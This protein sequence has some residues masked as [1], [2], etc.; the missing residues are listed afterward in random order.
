MQHKC[1]LGT[2]RIKVF[3]SSSMAKGEPLEQRAALM[4]FFERMLP[5]YE[6]YFFETDASPQSAEKDYLS[7]LED[8]D[9]V[10]L[11]LQGSVRDGVKKEYDAARRKGKRILAFTCTG[12]RRNRA[13]TEFVC[14]VRKSSKTVDFKDTRDLIDKIEHSLLLDLAR[15]Y[16]TLYEENKRL[17]EELNRISSQGSPYSLP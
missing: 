15:Q 3:V 12:R 17:T 5:L 9:I 13:L 10:I 16:V 1:D 14:E 4:A 6:A 7:R 2:N 8:S 11:V